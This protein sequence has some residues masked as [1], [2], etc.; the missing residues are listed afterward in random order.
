[1]SVLEAAVEAAARAAYIEYSMEPGFDAEA[2][3]DD[4]S[5]T[6]DWETGLW[7]LVARAALDAAAPHMARSARNTI[8]AQLRHWYHERMDAPVDPAIE[9]TDHEQGREVGVTEGI[10]AASLAVA[11]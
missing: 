3:W 2:A 1:M 11:G 8:S 10:L 9:L 4:M 7:M 6:E 5:G